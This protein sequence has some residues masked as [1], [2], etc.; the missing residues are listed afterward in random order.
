MGAGKG[1]VGVITGKV[2][3]Q[4]ALVKTKASKPPAKKAAEGKTG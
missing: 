1:K 4:K 3:P 2:K